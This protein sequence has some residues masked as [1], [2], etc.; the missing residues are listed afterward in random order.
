MAWEERYIFLIDK[1]VAKLA[2]H[3]RCWLSQ[4]TLFFLFNG[5]FLPQVV[6]LHFFDFYLTQL[7]V[8]HL[9]WNHLIALQMVK[10]SEEWST[11]SLILRSKWSVVS[12]R[13]RKRRSTDPQ[14]HSIAREAHVC[15]QGRK[16]KSVPRSKAWRR[17]TKGYKVEEASS[18]VCLKLHFAECRATI[19][20]TIRPSDLLLVHLSIK[21]VSID[22][23]VF[24]I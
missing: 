10:E 17:T 16:Q 5:L 24:H 13:Q 4:S 7:F 3:W 9:F 20:I 6:S 2:W 23:I 1:C 19:C 14:Q 21:F 15:V 18:A 12:Q 11:S 22:Y 8:A